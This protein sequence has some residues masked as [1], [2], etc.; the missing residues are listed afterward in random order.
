MSPPELSGDT[1]VADILQPV[2]IGLVKALRHEGQIAVLYRLDGGLRHL[3]HLYKPLLLD[4]GLHGR[5]AAVMGSHIVHMILYLY[6]KSLLLQLLH[7]GFSR[8]VAIHA[9]ILAAVLVDGG[10]VV[11]DVDLRQIVASSHLKVI[12]VMGR[13]NLYHAGSE[14]L[15]HISV[16]N[17]RNLT[18]HQGQN[19]GLSDDILVALVIRIDRQS[20]VAQHG[21]RSRGRDLHKLVAVLDRIID[22]PEM[23]GL[24]LMLHL[25]VRN[26]GL[27]DR[28]PV[29][30]PGTLVNI[31]LLI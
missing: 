6:Q 1:P 30:N 18:A 20:R 3:L 22:M 29:N 23:A 21:L 17:D 12:G 14:F 8:L 7:D 11:Q 19:H 16:R 2:E 4:H 5:A 31:S 24:L 13:R 15:I 28:T 25:R 27:A 26:G 10:V 9:R